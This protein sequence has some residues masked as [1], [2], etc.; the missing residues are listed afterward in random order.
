[1]ADKAIERPDGKPV[2]AKGSSSQPSQETAAPE[3]SKKA[4]DSSQPSSTKEATDVASTD[5]SEKPASPI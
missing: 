5:A 1:M 4:P 3:S 2:P